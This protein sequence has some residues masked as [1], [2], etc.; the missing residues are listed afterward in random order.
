V[1]EITQRQIKVLLAIE[2]GLIETGR[3]PSIRDLGS[4]MDIGSTRG[5]TTHLDALE[6]KGY[7]SRTSRPGEIK[8]LKN[9]AGQK[10]RL[11]LEVAE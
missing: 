7:I 9:A 11:V 3:C 6:R 8:I 4:T 5:V 10:V 2:Q 1:K